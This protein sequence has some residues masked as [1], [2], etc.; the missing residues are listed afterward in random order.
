MYL[1]QNSFRFFGRLREAI[2]GWFVNAFEGGEV[3]TFSPAML[4]VQTSPPA[5]LARAI[6][7]AV[8]AALLVFVAWSLWAD[9]DITIS[10]VGSAVPSAKT[11]AIQALE[12]GRVVAIHVKDGDVVTQGQALIELD[13]TLATAD[14]QRA[15]QDALDAELDVRRLQAQL[16]G[17]NRMPDM[18][19]KASS[20]DVER[21]QQLLMSRVA[22]QQQKLA[23]MDQEIARKAADLSATQASIRKIEEVLP[24]L[25]QRLLMREKLL[26]EGFLAEMGVIDSRLEVS[27]QSNELAV[28]K[29]RIR[30]SQS[31]LRAAQLAKQQTQ[32]EYIAKASAEMTDSRRRMQVGQQESVKASYRESYQVLTSPIAGSVQ[33]LVVN[34]V[35]GVV[36]AAQALMTVVPQ[37]GGIEV[38][39]NVLNKDVGFLRVGMP[40]TVKLDA[41]EFTKYGS[42]E[43][44][45]QWIGADAVKVEQLG[46]VYPVRILLK[47]TSLPIG[48]NGERP[49]IR[50][51]MSVVADVAIGK[52]KAYEFFLGPLLKYQ[53][54]SLRER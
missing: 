47:S 48:V 51:G 29:E 10:S 11:K 19:N 5:P 4:A 2:R 6:A 42:L 54:E 50:I 30:E 1:I 16:S 31:A 24:M 27:T 26:K 33:Q 35:G 14:R 22:E 32:A 34:T 40:A 18:A 38:E 43:G 8:A 12:V 25:Q 39:A 13:A 46:Q 3:H 7:W 23:V 37:E 21:Q 44:T 53:N 52:R 49:A 41:F 36:N 20:L 9:F 17:I 28:L 45:V 15:A